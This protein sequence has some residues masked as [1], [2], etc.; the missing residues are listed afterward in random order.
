MTQ[1]LRFWLFRNADLLKKPDLLLKKNYTVTRLEVA[2]LTIVSWAALMEG[3]CCQ[4]ATECKTR[5]ICIYLYISAPMNGDTVLT[6]DHSEGESKGRSFVL[7]SVCQE[8]MNGYGLSW[9]VL[10]QWCDWS[11]HG[12]YCLWWINDSIYS[13]WKYKR[14]KTLDQ[15]QNN[16]LT[17]SI[18]LFIAAN[19]SEQSHIMHL[20]RQ[21]N[22]IKNTDRDFL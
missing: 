16:L 22:V 11:G 10:F 2:F 4:L 13:L 17:V 5:Q 15:M 21:K 12:S 14:F 9:A 7:S 3:L 19:H 18:K 8:G 1:A 20:A 6:P